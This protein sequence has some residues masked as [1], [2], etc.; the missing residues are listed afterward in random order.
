MFK[1]TFEFCIFIV[2]IVYKV[3]KY[4]IFFGKHI[5]YKLIDLN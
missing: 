5:F 3:F 1:I 4:Y 2:R